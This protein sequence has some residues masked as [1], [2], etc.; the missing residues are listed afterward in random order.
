MTE[1]DIAWAMTFVIVAV[2]VVRWFRSGP[3]APDPWE[4]PAE[5]EDVIVVP[6][7]KPVCHHCFEPQ[8]TPAHFCAKCGAATGPYNNLLPYEQLFSVGEVL[9]NGAEGR[10]RKTPL[11]AIGYFLMST[12]EYLVF[13]PLYWFRWWKSDRT[14]SHTAARSSGDSA[15]H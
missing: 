2:L 14:N 9:R 3:V 12:V 1:T 7:D 15:E 6:G 13:A 4:R 8:P 10:V 11:T 5:G